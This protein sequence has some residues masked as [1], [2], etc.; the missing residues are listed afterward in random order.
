MDRNDPIQTRG[1]LRLPQIIG[2]RKRGLA[3]PI[4]V[5]RSTWWQGVK[6]GRFPAPVKIGPR[7]TAWRAEDI[8]ELINSL[9]GGRDAPQNCG[10]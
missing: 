5:S 7:T 9:A 6:D 3:G 4:P 10:G 2:D 1:F 8:Q